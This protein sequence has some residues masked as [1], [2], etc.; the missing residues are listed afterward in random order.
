MKCCQTNKRGQEGTRDLFWLAEP[1]AGNGRGKEER[2]EEEG[3]GESAFQCCKEL[4]PSGCCKGRFPSRGIHRAPL[5]LSP[6][7]CSIL[8]QGEFPPSGRVGKR[9]LGA[10]AGGQS[11]DVH[12]KE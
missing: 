12:P 11:R 7:T 9:F 5:L 6:S 3:E 4:L 2:E 8:P 1:C 10:R